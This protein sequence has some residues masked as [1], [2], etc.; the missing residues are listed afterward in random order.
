[1]SSSRWL[2]SAWRF[3]F[4][5]S[6][7]LLAVG[8][9][10]AQFAS[11]SPAASAAAVSSSESSS[12]DYQLAYNAEPAAPTPASG[13]AA[14]QYDNKSGGSGAH[15]WLGRM[16]WE[17]GGGF[18]APTSD[19]SQFVTWGGNF[20][21]GAGMHF[22]RGVSVLAEYQFIDD[23]LPGKLIAETGATG[24]ND[25]I[26]SLTIDPMIDLFP[27]HSNSVYITGGG[28]F[29]RKVTNFTNPQPQY[30]CSY[31]YCGVGYANA[32]VGHFSSNQGGWNVGG[33]ITHRFAGMY[34]DGRMQVFAEVRYLEVL[35]PA[36][37]VAPNGL[38]VTSVGADTKLIPVTFGVRF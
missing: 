23:K 36:M 12:N 30:F 15:G 25:H 1:M 3:A 16:A 31:F 13:A 32:V 38:G 27:K 5:G 35:S 4:L 14:G 10:N 7:A 29:Y 18:N 22:S 2:S 6:A 33:G 24:G 34:G 20:T 17:A 28:G 9:A 37:T 8:A 11:S 19:S 21:L 26:W